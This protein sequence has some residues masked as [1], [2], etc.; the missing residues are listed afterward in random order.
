M[1][2]LC[3]QWDK[4]FLVVVQLR[5]ALEI[6]IDGVQ[7]TADL[8]SVSGDASGETLR[9]ANTVTLTHRPPDSVVME[10]QG[11]PVGDAI[12]DTVIAVILQVRLL[13]K[14]RGGHERR[15]DG[16]GG[17]AFWGPIGLV[18]SCRHNIGIL[19]GLLVVST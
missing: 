19:H 12:A 2:T 18:L 10:W 5:L 3:S 11:D 16:V 6:V 8:G 17:A 13:K 7:G 1:L 4:A 15:S 9:V 14:N